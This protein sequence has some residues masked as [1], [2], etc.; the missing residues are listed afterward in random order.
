MLRNLINTARLVFLA[1]SSGSV[2][3]SGS[4]GK[5]LERC[6]KGLRAL[7]LAVS[8]RGVYFDAHLRRVR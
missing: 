1:L 4:T 8:L 6:L 5:V 7:G 3:V 2:G